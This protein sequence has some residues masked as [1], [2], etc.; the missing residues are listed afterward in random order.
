MSVSFV[1]PSKT[2]VPSVVRSVARVLEALSVRSRKNWRGT[3]IVG[4]LVPLCFLLSLGLGL[5]SLTSGAV[6]GSGVGYAGYL[7]PAL[8]ASAAVQFAVSEA[9][10]PVMAG[11]KWQRTYEAIVSTPVTS[12]QLV[13]GQLLWIGVRVFV[14]SLL[15]FLAMLIFG[16]VQNAWSVAIVVIAACGAL[17][18]AAPVMA[19]SA[20][21]RGATAFVLLTRLLVVPLSLTSG[22]FFPVDQLPDYAEYFAWA[23]PLAHLVALCREVS[24]GGFNLS[25]AV[26]HVA[27]PIV[28]LAVGTALAM[29]RFR[30]RLST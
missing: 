27:V 18:V 30:K 23:F 11:F 29:V 9:A 22:V 1:A 5:G 17:A 4:F 12:S 15:F 28:W 2:P 26:I 10:E 16:L 13:L 24:L 25:T 20:T 3:L 14:T 7:A 21:V 6:F 19:Y 8:L